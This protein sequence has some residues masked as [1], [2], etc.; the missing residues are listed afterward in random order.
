MLFRGN[1][2]Y[3]FLGRDG[4]AETLWTNG[5]IDRMKD[6]KALKTWQLLYGGL[7]REGNTG[8]A[9]ALYDNVGVVGKALESLGL[10]TGVGSSWEIV[11]HS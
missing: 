8:S 9:F 7:S 11:T 2:T 3:P 10:G 5:C 4:K 6:K 1:V